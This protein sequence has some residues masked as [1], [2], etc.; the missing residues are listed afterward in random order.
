MIPALQ[1]KQ[2][3]Y[4]Q[5]LWCYQDLAQECGGMNLFA[6]VDFED[7]GESYFPS[8]FPSSSPRV[9][10]NR[11]SFLSEILVTRLITPP[12]NGQILPG[13][14]RDSLLIL[15]RA[16]LAGEI[17]IEG[18]PNKNFD[19]EER[20]FTLTEL[21]RWSD[22]GRLKECFGAGTAVREFFR[23]RSPSFILF[24]QS[25]KASSRGY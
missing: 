20:E 15:T 5:N 12:L 23:S 1:A 6:V 16:H 2:M 17:V 3:G 11:S 4:D 21:R 13:I 22:Q 25:Q 18:L 8:F 9:L 7:G 24:F 19:I 14:T 10:I